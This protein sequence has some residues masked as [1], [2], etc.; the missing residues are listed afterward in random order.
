M[1]TPPNTAPEGSCFC[2]SAETCTCPKCPRCDAPLNGHTHFPPL[3]RQEE[4]QVQVDK[5]DRKAWDHAVDEVFGP[6]ME[7]V[8]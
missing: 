8:L 4:A 3:N 1:P 7:P 6:C 5:F 2:R